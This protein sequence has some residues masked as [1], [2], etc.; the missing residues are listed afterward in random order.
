MGVVNESVEDG[1]GVGRVADDLMPAVYGELGRDYRGAAT[2]ALFEDFEEI[3]TGGRIERL[4]PPIVE[5]QEVGAA[6]TAHEAGMTA[7]AAR[8]RQV[9]EQPRDGR[10]H[11]A[12]P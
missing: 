5:D 12:K 2:V 8:E 4:E 9:L 1:V 7:V 10:C 6:K 3:V 11:V